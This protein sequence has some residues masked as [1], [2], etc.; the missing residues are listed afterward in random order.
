LDVDSNRTA[1]L[2]RVVVPVGLWWRFVTSADTNANANSDADP[3]GK[4]KP[5]DLA[6]DGCTG[7]RYRTL[8]SVLRAECR[9]GS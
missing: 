5:Y 8:D 1:A 4:P 6:D 3:N 9:I 7:L 2:D